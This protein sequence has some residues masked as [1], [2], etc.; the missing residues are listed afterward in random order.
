MHEYELSAIDEHGNLVPDPRAKWAGGIGGGL[1]N[2][3]TIKSGESFSKTIALNR[4]AL[5]IKP[6]IY[7]VTGTYYQ[8]HNLPKV[9][10][11]PIRIEVL[12]RSDNEMDSYINKLSIKLS[13]TKDEQARA[14]IVRKLMYTCDSRTIPL[15]IE[16]IY[17]ADA[18]SYWAIEAFQ[19]YLPQNQETNDALLY[20]AKKRGLANGML[21][22][23]RQRGFTGEKIK[24]L[25]DVSLSPE[26]PYAW[27][28]G[29]LAAQEFPEDRF[30][31]RL[32]SIALD[33][34]SPARSQAVYALAQ[35]RTD[36]S[37]AALKKLLNE[38]DP[39]EPKGR[40]IRQ[41]TERAVRTAYW[42]GDNVKGRPLR[43]DDFDLKYQ[44]TSNFPP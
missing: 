21:W 3:G 16:A 12:P 6:G 1:S 43:K 9:T 28:E 2:Q 7:Q 4:W 26:R 17:K 38:P 41:I 10:S 23:L 34:E 8:A 39:Y 13:E 44:D 5:L 33:P 24:P 18:A 22:A 25:I 14:A 35:N 15:L 40:T 32:I 11:A 42:L 19:Y 31:P 37:V 29:A 27:V 36:E 30:T 20:A